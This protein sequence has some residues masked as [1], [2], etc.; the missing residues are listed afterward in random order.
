[1]QEHNN[2]NANKSK[3]SLKIYQPCTDNYQYICGFLKLIQHEF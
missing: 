2:F 1:M 3:P